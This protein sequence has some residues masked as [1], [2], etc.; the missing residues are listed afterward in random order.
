MKKL[1]IMALLSLISTLSYSNN[2]NDTL[3]PKIP[4]TALKAVSDSSTLSFKEVYSDVKEGLKGLSGALKV[5]TEH[6]YEVLVKQQY[7]NSISNLLLIIILIVAWIPFF[8]IFLYGKDPKRGDWEEML[9]PYTIFVGG[10]LMCLTIYQFLKIHTIITGFI[11]PE[12]GA[13]QDIMNFIKK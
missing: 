10:T 13:I 6:V 4:E 2:T 11:N 5:G 8:K 7:I 1:L 12:Y 3:P 9:I